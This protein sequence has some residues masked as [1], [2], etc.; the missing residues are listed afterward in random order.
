MNAAKGTLKNGMDNK[1]A[2]RETSR[3]KRRNPLN[4]LPLTWKIGG[5]FGALLLLMAVLAIVGYRGT[6]QV[7]E[8]FV[9]YRG[10]ARQN[11]LL[12]QI[13]AEIR[14][15]RIDA[16]KYRSG[17]DLDAVEDIQVLLESLREHEREISQLVTDAEMQQQ[18]DS[19]AAHFESYVANFD[20]AIAAQEELNTLIGNGLAKNHAAAI[21][22]LTNLIQS[23]SVQGNAEASFQAALVQKHLMLS[24]LSLQAYI[25]EGNEAAAERSSIEL[26]EA[27]RVAGLLSAELESGDAAAIFENVAKELDAYRVSMDRAAS[28]VAA[29]NTIFSQQLDRL[30]P[31]TVAEVQVLVDKLV[32]RQSTLGPEALAEITAVQD[33]GLL[34]T[35]FSLFL[36]LAFAV[37]IGRSITTPIRAMTRYMTKLAAGQTDF[38]LRSDNRGDEIGQMIRAMRDMTESILRAFTQQ[39]MIEEMPQAVMLADPNDDLKLTYMNRSARELMDKLRCELPCGPD[40]M[41]GQSIDIFHSDPSRQRGL[42]MTPERLPHRARIKL[43]GETVDLHISAIMNKDGSYMGPMLA[44]N[45]VTALASMADSFETDVKGSLDQL[46]SA[47]QDTQDRMKAMATNASDAQER[48]ANVASAAEEATASVE[49]VASASEELTSSIAEIGTQVTRASDMSQEV[50]SMSDDT[51]NKAE[52]LAEAS[53]RIGEVITLISD[54]AAQTNLLALNATIEA[55]RAGEAGKGFAV[56]ASEVKGLANQTAQATEEI[57]AQISAMRSVTDETVESVESVATR[58]SEMNEIFTTVASAVEEQRAATQEISSSVHQAAQGTQGVTRNIVA[59][60]QASEETGRSAGEVLSGTEELAN[61]LDGL[62][63]A[64]EQ[65]LSSVRSA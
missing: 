53:S 19:I 13:A 37:L 36:G 50:A 31:S 1:A 57:S 41:L 40:E 64:S 48:S 54:I 46:R 45:V 14:D 52:S 27:E 24:R 10:I 3:R 42:L 61:T 34:V 38:H 49:T 21:E 26:A 51:R 15:A 16:F 17:G 58:I 65:F 6:S 25:H 22:G 47:F 33:R 7:G 12:G 11:L 8:Q 29:R 9:E 62:G 43:S 28:L 4:N 35:A 39:Q 56:V 23:T 63:G 2:A 20:R 30:G 18:L 60:R 32:G 44:W 59:V 5:G 55:A